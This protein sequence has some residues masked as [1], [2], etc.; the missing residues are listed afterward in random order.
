[1]HIYFCPSCITAYV[2]GVYCL[3]EEKATLNIIRHLFQIQMINPSWP[4][5]NLW[6][7]I[8][9][10]LAQVNGLLLDG[11]KPLPKPTL[12]YNQLCPVEFIMA[13]SKEQLAEDSHQ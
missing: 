12:T 4:S 10:T 3:L 2:H 13:F 8:W 6:L 11:T 1:M 7:H 9:V 5:D